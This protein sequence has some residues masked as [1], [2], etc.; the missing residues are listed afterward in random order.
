VAALAADL[1]RG[2]TYGTVLGLI[3]LGNRLGS[4]LGPWL[5]GVIYDLTGRYRLAFGVAIAAITG[6]AV[7]LAAAGRAGPPPGRA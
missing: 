4:A 6:A 5:G 3:T 7:T 2:R 1:Y